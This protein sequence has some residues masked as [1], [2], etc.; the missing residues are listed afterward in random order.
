[1]ARVLE[2][3]SPYVLGGLATFEEE[4]PSLDEMLHRRRAVLERG[5]PYLVGEHLGRVVGYSYATGHRA[6]PAYRH[7]I[8]NSVY[9]QDGLTGLGVGKALLQ[10][11]IERC[12]GGPW[13][14]MIAVVGNSANEASIGLHR[15]CGFENVGILRSVGFKLDQWVDTVLLQRSLNGG[16]TTRPG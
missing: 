10:A 11:L 5:L 6:R 3:Y 16:D 8:E 15:S 13:R 7:T 4:C 2:I 1:M 9:V 12:T 14:Q